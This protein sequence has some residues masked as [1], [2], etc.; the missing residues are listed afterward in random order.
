MN[1]SFN[2]LY[3]FEAFYGLTPIDKNLGSDYYFLSN[4]VIKYSSPN[5]FEKFSILFSKK[6]KPVLRSNKDRY[7]NS[8]FIGIGNIHALH[9]L[10]LFL[11][12][13]AYN[14]LIFIDY[15]KNQILHLQ[16]CIYDILHSCN[17]IDFIKR[18]FCI[19]LNS[20]A[21]HIL[22]SI[23]FSPNYIHGEVDKDSSFIQEKI[24]WSNVIFDENQ[25]SKK[26][27]LKAKKK[28]AGLEIYANTIGDINIYKAT[29][30]SCG[31]Q[32]H[33]LHVFTLA[34]GSGF[35]ASEEKFLSLQQTLQ[36]TPS[37]F[38]V[39]DISDIFE[40][41]LASVKYGP[42]CI[43]LSN[44]IQDYFIKKNHNLT[45]IKD[46]LYKY[47]KNNGLPEYEIT[48]LQDSRVQEWIPLVFTEKNIYQRKLSTHS[49][50]FS[51]ICN[52]IKGE[53]LEVVN[54]NRWIKEDNGVSKLNQATYILSKEFLFCQ[55]QYD[56]IFLHILLGH[57][58][59][60][61]LFFKYCEH[62]SQ[63]TKNLIILEHYKN[64]KDFIE[65][66]I[67]STPDEIQNRL[68]KANKIGFIPGEK[69]HDRNFFLQYTSINK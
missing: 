2:G 5:F 40:N 18:F 28:E 64:S 17:R 43:W 42:I 52:L 68:G 30:F 19:D 7:N 6:Y 49:K 31:L 4:D 23:H 63:L 36:K 57:G 41:I 9:A 34:F 33:K 65:K 38:I 37:C 55:R 35:L 59:D 11:N 15:N 47:S 29:L 62:A 10:S 8:S 54:I 25:F 16:Q 46:I 45:R 53:T 69:T 61:E 67:G 24:F 12:N 60:K 50:T 14:K 56:S 1:L 20:T 44:L 21:E 32:E 13:Y 26:Y 3:N 22:N 58:E 51:V 27:N 48:I 66:G 39:D